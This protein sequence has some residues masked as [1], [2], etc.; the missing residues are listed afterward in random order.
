MMKLFTIF[1]VWL[2]ALT[3]LHASP[4][5]DR[6]TKIPEGTDR[7]NIFDLNQEDFKRQQ[8]AGFIH[9]LR[10]PVE[11]S[12]LFIPYE[13]LVRFLEADESNPLRRLIANISR[14]RVGF[15]NLQEMYDWIGLNPYNDEH[16]TG[17]YQI[18]YP[19]GVR[20]HY[21]MGASLVQTQH[22]LGLSFS[23]A[24]CHS[25]NLFGTSVMGLT[26]KRVRANEFFHTAK[27]YVPMVPS[28]LFQ[29]ATGATDQERQMFRRT[30]YNLGAVGVKS[31]EALGLDTSLGQ[32][33]LS[34]ARRLNDEFATKSPLREQFPR[35]NPL[36]GDHIADSK[37]MVWWNLKYK[38]RWLADGSIVS[39]NPILTNFLWN[40]I[41]RG[42]DL[43]EL[44]G[45]FE[46]NEQTIQE[47]TVAAFSTRPPPYTDFF[48]VRAINIEKAKRGQKHFQESCQSCHGDYQKAWDS[49]DAWSLSDEELVRTTRLIY[50]EETPVKDVGT[51]PGRYQGTKYFASRLNELRISKWMKTVVEPQVGYVPP[52][53][54]GIWARYPYFHNNSIPNLCAL[55]TPPAKR[56]KTFWTGPAVDKERDFDQECIGYPVG[57][58]IP[59]QWKKDKDA[60]FDTQRVGMSNQGHYKMFLHEDGSEKYDAQQKSE[61]REF[62][63]TL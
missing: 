39:G 4:S 44:E 29:E 55:M 25:A 8:Q 48:G 33:A 38:N 61:L 30:K 22:G 11:V 35:Y 41:G 23:C 17:I 14:S 15:G 21:P 40:E 3:S 42:T 36:V 52:P 16:A 26:N 46:R 12:G 9:A 51:D 32:V 5:W 31:P 53:L 59:A 19:D 18:P 2:F 10:Y 56:P 43:E 1:A 50:H 20:P 7:A 37:P 24:T 49:E 28:K 60:F 45:W 6:G 57:N 63:K 13:P 54:D 27:K 47:L 34:L 58:A 62:L